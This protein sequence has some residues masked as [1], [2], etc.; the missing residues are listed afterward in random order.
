[1]SL[2]RRLMTVVKQRADPRMVAK[3]ASVYLSARSGAR[4]VVRYD[5][6]DWI[7]RYR[8]GV[9]VDVRPGGPTPGQQDRY[10][11]DLFLFDYVPRPG[12]TVVDIGAGVGGEVRLLSRL[13]GPLGRVVSIEAHPRTFRCLTRTIQANELTN[14]TVLHCAVVDRT[15]PVYLEDRRESHIRNGLTTDPDA[16]VPVPGMALDEILAALELDRID[17]LKMN[18]E[19]AEQ[20]VLTSSRE[21]LRRVDHMTISCHDFLADTSGRKSQR[22]FAEVTRLLESA[23]YTIRTRPG[24]ERPWVPY[25]VYASRVPSTAIGPVR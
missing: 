15:G 7:H 4:C 16:G 2:R 6:G 17:L 10:A 11:R 3:L 24:D 14:V 5:R 20:A 22:T 19:G 12:D 23:G 8:D 1:M 21:A 25:Y 18:I 13:V 9:I